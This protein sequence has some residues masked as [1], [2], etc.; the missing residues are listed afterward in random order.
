MEVCT[1]G[2][3]LA[4]EIRAVESKMKK[5]SGW[6]YKVVERSGDSL[7]NIL[8]KA[9][10]W[11]GQDSLS[12]KC[13]LCRTKIKT[14]KHLTQDCTKRNIIYETWCIDCYD[15]DKRKIEEEYMEDPKTMKKK[16]EDIKLF[17]YAG[18]SSRSV[19]ER[20]WEHENSKEKLH[21]DSLS[22]TSM[23]TRR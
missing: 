23:V 9:D 12:T 5:I 22:W 2:S 19:Y 10:S 8:H 6:H 3:V 16:L 7:V 1:W 18:E 11:A 21:S 17:K 13:M 15:E 20:A 4:K 14:G